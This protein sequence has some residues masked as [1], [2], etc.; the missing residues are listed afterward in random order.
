MDL[1]TV[2]YAFT[3]YPTRQV[4]GSVLDPLEDIINLVSTL[5]SRDFTRELIQA[6][7]GIT[8][9]E[10]ES[11]AEKVVA[12]VATAIALIRQGLAGEEEVS[13]LPLYYGI[14]DLLKVY[15][16]IGPYHDLLA[17]QAWHGASYARASKESRSILTEQIELK[18]KG[19]LPLF[20]R[21]TTGKALTRSRKIVMRD[22]FCLL[23]DVSHEY[24]TARGSIEH[25][26]GAIKLRVCNSPGKTLKQ[27]FFVEVA[28]L[29]Q[30]R[31]VKLRQ[32]GALK[33]LQ[34]VPGTP[35]RYVLP[36]RVKAPGG[37]RAALERHIAFEY[38][39]HP[40]CG[41]YLIPLTSGITL[42]TEEFPIALLFFHMGSVVR[43]NPEFL[44]K[45]RSSRYWPMLS[46]ART[47]SLFKFLILFW[48]FVN[49]QT[50]LI[51]HKMM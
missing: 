44:H 20:L 33:G 6:R 27:T 7:H 42:F 22:V 30:G 39:Y 11:R 4:F 17:A 15:I 9:A 24:N 18:T 10:A 21:T 43:Y 23:A 26:I 36:I 13:F 45:I 8:K 25:N 28:P 48:S 3:R 34:S 16:L 14:L 31:I 41:E 40:I 51:N 50:V 47:H 29:Q 12:H 35:N 37:L 38:L 5:T 32:V 2:D 46:A 49:Q 19:A 1:R